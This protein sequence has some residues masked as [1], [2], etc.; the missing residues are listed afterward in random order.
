MINIVFPTVLA[1]TIPIILGLV[2]A[3]LTLSSRINIKDRELSRPFECGFRPVSR[4]RMP[5]SLRFFLLAVLFLVFDV[6]IVVLIPRPLILYEIPIT[7][8]IL[9]LYVF[10]IIVTIGLLH[11]WNEGSLD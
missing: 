5:F 3:S 9:P 8:F 6:E 10:L 4:A 11:E 1:I 7:Y 2:L